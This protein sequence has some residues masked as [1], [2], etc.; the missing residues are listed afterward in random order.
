MLRKIY[1]YFFYDAERVAKKNPFISKENNSFLLKTCRFTLIGKNNRV[2]IGSES[3]IGCEFVF[4]SDEGMI[5]IGN[6]SFINAGTKLISRTG[7][8]I[9]NN[10]TI[11]WGCTIYD[12][13][14]HSLSYLSRR[15][16]IE[17]QLS[18]Y[19]SGKNFIH[20]KDWSTVKSRKIIIEDDA[21]IGF[22]VTILNGVTIGEGAIV[23]A[24]SVVRDNVEPWT[25]VAGNPA[26][27]IKRLK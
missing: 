17:K 24:M 16:D 18:D 27:I 26:V 9:G 3:M 2:V 4:E 22:G 10:V 15:K 7:I 14:S 13:N 8:D 20:S 12:H 5:T 25:I 11:A 23:S 21:W 19:R 1:D 6:R